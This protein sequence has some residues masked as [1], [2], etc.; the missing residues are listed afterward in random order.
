MQ[1]FSV[2]TSLVKLT[3]IETVGKMDNIIADLYKDFRTRIEN[4]IQY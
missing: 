3:L 1:T 4:E 2:Y